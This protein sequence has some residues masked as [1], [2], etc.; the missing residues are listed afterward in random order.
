MQIKEMIDAARHFEGGVLV[1]GLAG[2]EKTAALYLELNNR[3]AILFSRAA[4]E[5]ETAALLESYCD[6]L[7]A[8]FRVGNH[9]KWTYLML[10]SDEQIEQ[11]QH[12]WVSRSL[13][14]LFMILQQQLNKSFFERQNRPFQHAWH[15]LLKFGLVEL[16]FTPA[17]IEEEYFD[18]FRNEFNQP[19]Y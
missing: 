2:E 5:K 19:K 9:Q 6:V 8:F 15:L 14:K 11:L 3:L 1:E 4:A 18:K 10:L 17:Q 16:G 13:A 7:C 12:K